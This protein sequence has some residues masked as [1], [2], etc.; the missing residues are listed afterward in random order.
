MAGHHTT[1][2]S[3]P[4]QIA[5]GGL[6]G[7][8]TA[9][10]LARQGH[11]V[12]LFEK[13]SDSGKNRSDDWDA[14]ENWTT[15]RDLRL[16]FEQWGLSLNFYHHPICEFIVC[17]HRGHCYPIAT[18]SP[19]FYLIS[20]GSQVGT[21][22]QSLKSQA[23]DYGVTIHY[24]Q[25]RAKQA[26]DIW[27][28]GIQQK[29]F[30]LNAGITFATTHPDVV[31]AFV[32]AQTAPRAYAYLIIVRGRGKLAVVLTRHFRNARVLLEAV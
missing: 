18:S 10:H 5:G 25:M 31:M 19:L 13:N 7:L 24:N 15:K 4:L 23:L 22:E 2:N 30:F 32:N 3:R 8:S 1:A 11:R 27:A 14:A 17:D 20:R 6:A 26:V 21:L 28:T 16:L 12:E 29:G 9:I